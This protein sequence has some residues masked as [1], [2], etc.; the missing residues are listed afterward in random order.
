MA[1]IGRKGRLW[2]RSFHI[3]FMVLWIGAV[4][5]QVVILLFSGSAKSDGAL[6][7]FNAVPQI[8]NILTGPGC[9]GTIVTGVLLSWLTPW[10]FFKHKWIIYTM[11]VVVLDLVVAQIFG[12]PVVNKMAALAEAEGLSAL[13]NPEY[14]SAWNRLVILSSVTSLLLISAAFVSVIKPWRK[15]KELEAAE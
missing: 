1:K 2:L 12:E 6:Q 14:V 10:G 8:L 4:V 5:S 13:Q 9:L 7:A 11:V 15:R 3:F